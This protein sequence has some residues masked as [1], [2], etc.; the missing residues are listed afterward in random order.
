MTWIYSYVVFEL[1]QLN[2]HSSSQFESQDF[3]KCV[4]SSFEGAG[5]QAF[6]LDGLEVGH[7]M[8]ALAV[9]IRCYC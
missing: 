4:R 1:Q 5:L 7:K 8:K 3:R 6:G 2:L 9:S